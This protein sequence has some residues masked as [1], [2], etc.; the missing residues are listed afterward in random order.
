[1]RSPDANVRQRAAN[2]VALVGDKAKGVPALDAALA[3]EKDAP[4]R[5]ML[6][7]ARTQLY[8]RHGLP[9][10]KSAPAAKPAVAPATK[11]TVKPAVKSTAKPAAPKPP[12][13]RTP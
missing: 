5:M 2:V 1:M 6:E 13:R 9:V 10:P 3:A 12:S 7:M 11:P 4:A 8:A